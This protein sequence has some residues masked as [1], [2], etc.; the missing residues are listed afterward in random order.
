[1]WFPLYLLAACTSVVSSPDATVAEAPEQPVTT[2]PGPSPLVEKI[3]ASDLAKRLASPAPKTRVVNFWATWCAPCVTEIPLLRGWAL[4][5]D[6]VDLVLVNLD[7]IS[8]HERRVLPFV[9]EQNLVLFKNYQLSDSDPAIALE[10]SID[11]FDGAVPF[12]LVLPSGNTAQRQDLQGSVT[13]ED[14]DRAISTL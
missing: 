5:H 4:E 12:T 14:L 7:L 2:D 1:M 10:E 6:D 8:R 3:A 9:E 11:E 13:K